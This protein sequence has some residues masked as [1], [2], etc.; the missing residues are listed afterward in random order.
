MEVEAETLEEAVG[1]A[2]EDYTIIE[3][4]SYYDSFEVD[5]I[6]RD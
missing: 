5:E 4:Y 2:E 1:I 3:E 6:E